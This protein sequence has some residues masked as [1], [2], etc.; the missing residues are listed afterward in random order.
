MKSLR[1]VHVGGLGG[2]RS[3]ED[4]RRLNPFSSPHLVPYARADA[5][6]LVPHEV[7]RSGYHLQRRSAAL[8][9]LPPVQLVLES[10][11]TAIAPD[12]LIA[13]AARHPIL[14]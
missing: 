3:W 7:D 1:P 14:S 4:H 6:R 13:D 12:Q 5:H 9:E 2:L 11:G 10:T 8:G